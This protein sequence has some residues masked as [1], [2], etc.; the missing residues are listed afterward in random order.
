MPQCGGALRKVLLGRC[1][2]ER[3]IGLG[4]LQRLREIG[5]AGDTIDR[6]ALECPSIGVRH[7]GDAAPRLRTEYAREVLAKVALPAEKKAPCFLFHR[8]R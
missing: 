2:D 6:R 1:I 4:G 8:R 3:D 7:G 5:K